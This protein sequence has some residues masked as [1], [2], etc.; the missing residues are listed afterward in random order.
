MRAFEKNRQLCLDLI[1]VLMKHR[2]KIE[3]LDVLLDTIPRLLKDVEDMT[4][5]AEIR[6]LRDKLD[7]SAREYYKAASLLEAAGK[8]HKHAMHLL[9]GVA[10]GYTQAADELRNIGGIPF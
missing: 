10:R 9:R 3:G 7:N 8:E 4:P 1:P 5:D 6:A 2:D